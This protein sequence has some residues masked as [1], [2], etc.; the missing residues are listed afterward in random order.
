MISDSPFRSQ[1]NMAILRLKELTILDKIKEKWWD[2]M[3]GA[4]ECE[5]S[6]IL[7]IKFNIWLDLRI[8]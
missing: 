1:I 3:D 4:I 7:K 6:K 2:N 5:V 8:I